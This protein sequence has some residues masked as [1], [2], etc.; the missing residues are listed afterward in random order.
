[1]SLELVSHPAH[2]KYRRAVIQKGD[3]ADANGFPFEAGFLDVV[4]LRNFISCN[5]VHF[6]GSGERNIWIS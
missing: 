3:C 6:L 1:M 4:S 2:E 5:K